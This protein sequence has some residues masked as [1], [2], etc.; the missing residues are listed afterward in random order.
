VPFLSIEEPPL[1]ENQLVGLITSCLPFLERGAGRGTQR[2]ARAI[3]AVLCSV[4]LLATVGCEKPPF[5]L[6]RV[7]GTVTI[8]GQKLTQGKVMFTPIAKEGELNPG[9]P[10]FGRIQPDGY[11]V[12]S[13]YS[14]EDGAIVGEHGVTVITSTD[15][16]AGSE[17]PSFSRVSLPRR[18]QVIAGK[19]NQIDIEITRLDVAQYGT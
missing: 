15:E 12:L 18:F 9:K 2:S 16:T 19:E 4:V 8:D 13:T 7:K 6:A 10:A 1:T 11:F 14:N 17:A 3:S 5:D